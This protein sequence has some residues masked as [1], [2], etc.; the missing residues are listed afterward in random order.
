MSDTGKPTGTTLPTLD[1]QTPLMRQYLRFKAKYKDAILFFRM[2]DFYEMF[3]DDAKIA[4]QVLGIALTSRAH[5]KAANVP[6]AGFPHHALDAY[7]TKMVKAG[8]KVAIC[9]QVE[10]PKKAKVVVK[11]DVLEVVTP[12][13]VL[14]DSLLD[15]KRNNFLV[16]LYLK[17]EKCGLAAADVSTG[18]FV[19]GEFPLAQ[20]KEQVVRAEP[21]EL[22][23]SEEQLP[24]VTE[25]LGPAQP[26]M[27]SKCEEW[28]FHRDYAYELLTQHFGTTSLRGFGCEDLDVGVSA[29]GA[30][31]HY[32]KE[33]QKNELRHL[34]RLSRLNEAEY[35]GL[36]AST[37]RNLELVTPLNPGAT[38]ATLLSVIDRTLTPMGGRMLVQWLLR[39]LTSKV[40]IDRRLDAVEELVAQGEFRQRIR[41]QLRRVGDLERLMAKVNTGRANARDLH[42]LMRTLALIPELKASCASLESALLRE[43]HEQLAELRPLVDELRRAL[44]DE[45]PVL[46]TEGGIIRSGYNA[47]LDELRAIAF[48][49]KDWIAKLQTR[50]RERTGIPSLK[51]NYNKVFGYYIEVTKPHLSKVPADYVRKQTT[52]GAERFITPELK[53]YEEK[54]LGAEEKMALLEYELFDQLRKRVA[55]ETEAVQKNARLLAQLDCLASLADVAVSNRYVRPKI[56]EST[57]IVLKES[58]HPVI[59][60][61]LPAGQPFVPNDLFID[62]A[63]DQI[64]IIT[65]PNMAGKSTYLRQVGLIVIMAQMGSFVPAKEAR[66]GLVDRIFTRVGASDNLAGGESTFLTEMNETANIL[67]NATPRSLILLDEIGRG[68]STFDGLSIAWA[69]AEFLHNTPRLAAKTMF[70]THYH[71]LTELALI[72]PR[73]KNYNVAVKEWGDRVVF[74]RKIVE[75]GCDHSYGI[76]VAQLA[77]LPREVIERAKEILANLEAE[78]LTPSEQPKLAARRSSSGDDAA[79]QLQLD[80]FAAQERYLAE[81]LRSIDLDNLTPLQAL[82]KLSELKKKLDGENL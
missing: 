30:V 31:V 48:S 57:A 44:V 27:V 60:R 64:L 3:Y 15:T 17:G 54:V 37:R 2:G 72:L 55:L 25:Q 7:L 59:E 81:E 50:E 70:A 19:A 23:V 45:P 51:V 39:P 12:G 47:E 49:G 78:A 24:Y 79:R 62:S 1:A 71:E 26:A 82:N 56:N 74:L 58:R 13:T 40:A 75:G 66:I 52:V 46:V 43:I 16:A 67:N 8:Y 77:G 6:L 14:S 22:L 33:N 42:A 63:S 10:D 41:D 11:R 38:H 80:I 20:L 5:G 53:E 69:V 61:L 9:E 36:D 35:L 18:D 73:V 32:L 65:G 4:S 68:T 21:A 34:N 76:Y 28:V 29:A